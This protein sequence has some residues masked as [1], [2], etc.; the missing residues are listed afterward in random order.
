MLTQYS[1]WSFFSIVSISF[2]GMLLLYWGI[3][4]IWYQQKISRIARYHKARKQ[5]ELQ[6]NNLLSPLT[7]MVAASD[8]DI[9]QRFHD[10]GIKNTLLAQWFMPLKYSA[11]I[12]GEMVIALVAH[13]IELDRMQWIAVAAIWAMVAITLPDIWLNA[14][15]ANRQRRIS[16]SLPYLID[17][18]SLIHI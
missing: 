13:L 3:S 6:V 1:A 18:L 9:Q 4:R 12:L 10:A 2:G 16:R 11:L 7:N 15:K 8:S 17:L 14:R 5:S